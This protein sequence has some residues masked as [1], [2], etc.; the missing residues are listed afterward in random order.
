MSNNLSDYL[1]QIESVNPRRNSVKK[2]VVESD[3]FGGAS[4][5]GITKGN[6]VKFKVKLS[7]DSFTPEM[8]LA[9]FPAWCRLSTEADNG[10]YTTS[11]L[12]SQ[13]RGL[14]DSW[15]FDSDQQT[16]TPLYPCA[17]STH[18]VYPARGQVNRGLAS[19]K[20]LFSK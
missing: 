7:A 3:G 2:A 8:Y 15:L 5:Y 17:L 16:S 10:G 1:E 13:A 12:G 20:T 19:L 11:L 6:V 4:T 9:A 14:N 18:F